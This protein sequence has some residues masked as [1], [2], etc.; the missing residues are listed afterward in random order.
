MLFAIILIGSTPPPKFQKSKN[1]DM[2]TSLVIFLTF[3]QGHN[4]PI[5]AIAGGGGGGGLGSVN[6]N[7]SKKVHVM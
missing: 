7:I 1:P 5:L 4:L 6:F 2:A 3:W